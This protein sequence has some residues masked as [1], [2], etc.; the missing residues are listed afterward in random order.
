MG[1]CDV[2]KWG[3]GSDKPRKGGG[4]GQRRVPSVWRMRKEKKGKPKVWKSICGWRGQ[5]N[6]LTKALFLIVLKFSPGSLMQGSCQPMGS[7]NA[8]W[9]QLHGQSQVKNMLVLDRPHHSGVLGVS[10]RYIIKARQP[11]C[12]CRQEGGHVC[13]YLSLNSAWNTKGNSIPSIL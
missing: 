4:Q 13:S 3:Q 2:L 6:S 1:Y 12:R 10:Y 9:S 5:G 7:W 11:W 8:V